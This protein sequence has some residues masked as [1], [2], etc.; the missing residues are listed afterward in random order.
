MNTPEE[1]Q[2]ALRCHAAMIVHCDNECNLRLLAMLCCSLPSPGL[3]ALQRYRV[4]AGER[5]EP[6][7]NVALF[8]LRPHARLPA[9]VLIRQ[10]LP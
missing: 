8:S 6:E 10:P 2:Q 4:H 3:W 9:A 7:I 1:L 5:T